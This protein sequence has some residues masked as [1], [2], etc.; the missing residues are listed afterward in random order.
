MRTATRAEILTSAELEVDGRIDAQLVVL[1]ACS[2][3]WGRVLDGDEPA[4]LAESFL[5]I[6]APSVIAPMWDSDYGPTREWAQ[7]FFEAWAGQGYPKALAA[8][9]ATRELRDGSYA[10]RPERLGAL[11]LRGDWL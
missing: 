11:T 8:R 10:D 4:S 5:H 6:G 7:R 9:H 3:G 2:T 1:L